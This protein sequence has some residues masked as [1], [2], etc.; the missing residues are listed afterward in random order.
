[1]NW[2]RLDGFDVDD[3]REMRDEDGRLLEIQVDC[4]PNKFDVDLCCLARKLVK[5][6]TRVVKY[7]DLRLDAA[8]TFLHVTRQQYQCKSCDSTLYQGVP[9]VDGKHF[10][11]ER[12]RDAVVL[13]SIKRTFADV[14]HVHGVI[15]PLFSATC[16][17]VASLAVHRVSRKAQVAWLFVQPRWWSEGIAQAAW[18]VDRRYVAR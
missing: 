5:N 9:H 6:G 16:L 17:I 18:K 14:E 2:L 15:T 3:P 4:V 10:V 7:R 11:T 12:L 13:S 8:P 1:M